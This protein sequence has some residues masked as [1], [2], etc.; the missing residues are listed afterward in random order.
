MRKTLLFLIII[1]VLVVPTF[2]G[3][4]RPGMFSTQDFPFIRLFEF[5]RCVRD[6]QLPCRWTPD[7]GLFYGEPLFNFYS[8][9]SYALGE[10]IHLVGF[11]LIDS[12]KGLFL[13]SF[14]LSGVSMFFLSRKIW[15]TDLAGLI[16]GIIYVYAPYRAVDVWVR[17][18]LAEAFSFVIFP[19]I[20]LA[21]EGVVE[22]GKPRNYILFGIS[23]ALLIL[24]HNLSVVL[25]LPFLIVWIT[26]RIV[27]KKKWNVVP[28]LALSGVWALALSAFYIL[29]L[30]GESK[31][32]DLESTT[33]GYF[34]FRAHFV[35]LY[36]LLIS[37]FWG[38]GG[39][40]WGIEDG[41]SLAVGIVQ[42][43]LPLVLVALFVFNRKKQ[44]LVTLLVLIFAGWFYLFLTHNKSAFIWEAIGPMKYIQ[45]PWRFLGQALFSFSIAGGAAGLVF[46]NTLRRYILGF[47]IIAVAILLNFSFFR[48]DLW[49][50]Y[51]DPDLTTGEK[52]VE[53]TRASIGDYWPKSVKGLIPKDPAPDSF[54]NQKLIYKKSDKAEYELSGVTKESVF[55]INYFP[56]WQGYSDGKKLETFASHEGFVSVRNPGKTVLILFED[57]NIRKI[58]NIISIVGLFGFIFLFYKNKSKSYEK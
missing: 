31:F 27:Q 20:I 35:T 12:L 13:L 44:V 7:I 3:M 14:V 40:T 8:Q 4:L 58:G 30:L 22:K 17:G 21:F 42:W 25:F 36:Q 55:P 28:G 50:S 49:F 45:F 24:T 2:F 38:Y 48:Q 43:V 57:T 19:L 9:L 54:K 51:K 32:V 46:K 5:D 1:L 11:S 10:I 34:D 37:R 18:N 53:Q 56:G 6:L 41:L 15:K 23:L 16:S 26:Y 33:K 52:F 47:A 29:P 39:S